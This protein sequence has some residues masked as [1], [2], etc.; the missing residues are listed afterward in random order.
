[1]IHELVFLAGAPVRGFSEPGLALGPLDLFKY[2]EM[3]N[4]FIVA[5]AKLWLDVNQRIELDANTIQCPRGITVAQIQQMPDATRSLCDGLVVSRKRIGDDP[6]DGILAQ[7]NL[8]AGISSSEALQRASEILKWQ[9]EV[10]DRVGNQYKDELLQLV[11]DWNL[12]PVTLPPL[13]SFGLQQQV[14]AL[15]ET[16]IVGTKGILQI[17]G[18]AVTGAVKFVANDAV[19][20]AD[21]LTDTIKVLPHIAETVS[22]PLLWIAGLGFVTLAGAGLV[23]YYVPR[24]SPERRTKRRKRK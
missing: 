13:P 12:P 18:Y 22:N 11:K 20:I 24:A 14:R 1:M 9:Q 2:R 16:A 17:G 6:S 21:G 5:H 3:W 19:A 10:V 15:I 23:M 7:W 8:F 4:P